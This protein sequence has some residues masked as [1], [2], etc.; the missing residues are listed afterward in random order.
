ML[1]GSHYLSQ[2]SF[3]NLHK[4]DSK[5]YNFDTNGNLY[6]ICNTRNKSDFHAG[7]W[8]RGNVQGTQSRVLNVKL[9][10]VPS[11]K[12][13]EFKLTPDQRILYGDCC[14]KM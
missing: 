14:E 13:P 3:Y 1:A 5:L 4:L 7:T 2:R 6:L 8:S 11:C 9:A 10:Y 12:R